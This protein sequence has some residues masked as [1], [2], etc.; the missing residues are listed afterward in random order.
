MSVNV[1][2]YDTPAIKCHHHFNRA[3]NTPAGVGEADVTGHFSVRYSGH[4]LFKNISGP[5]PC[6]EGRWCGTKCI[7][8]PLGVRAYNVHGIQI[9]EDGWEQAKLVSPEEAVFKHMR[10]NGGSSW[11]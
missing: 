5:L 10:C 2:E 8:R 9:V 3:I 4:K 6:I 1:Q 7:V 11:V